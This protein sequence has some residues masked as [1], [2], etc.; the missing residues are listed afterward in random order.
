MQRLVQKYD[1]RI[2]F[3][4]ICDSRIKDA[5]LNI[6]Y[7]TKEAYYRFFIP[8]YCKDDKCLYLDADII[9]NGNITNLFSSEFQNEYVAACRDLFIE[10]SLYKYTLGMDKPNVYFNSGVLLMNVH[11][12][13]NDKITHLLLSN[14]ARYKDIIEYLDQDILNITFE[15]RV[16]EL[17]SVYNY[18]TTNLVEEKNKKRIAKIIHYTGKDKPWNA[19]H[20]CR[21]AYLWMYYFSLLDKKD[22][23]NKYSTM[24]IYLSRLKYMLYK[25]KSEFAFRLCERIFKL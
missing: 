17:D 14:M 18:A 10:K 9:V 16:K 7:I 11:Q 19:Y 23:E 12:L 20:E 5:K 1:S 21:L 25:L 6:S 13:K 22:F 15:G 24:T 3:I 2:Q 4:S 8:E